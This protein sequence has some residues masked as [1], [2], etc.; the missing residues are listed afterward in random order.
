MY[1]IRVKITTRMKQRIGILATNRLWAWGKLN[2]NG[3]GEMFRWKIIGEDLFDLLH[4]LQKQ[5]EARQEWILLLQIMKISRKPR[6]PPDPV[7]AEYD[8]ISEQIPRTEEQKAEA[9][10]KDRGCLF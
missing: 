7:A 8:R 3:F 4:L 1:S 10:K 5:S 2:L 9:L 6:S